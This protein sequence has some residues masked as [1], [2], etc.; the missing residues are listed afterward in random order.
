MKSLSDDFMN[1]FLQPIVAAIVVIFAVGM[2]SVAEAGDR[3]DYDHDALSLG[4]ESA[5]NLFGGI[6]GGG[7]FQSAGNGGFT[8][9]NVSLF[10][11]K[12]GRWIGAFA[13]GQYDFPARSFMAL[14]GAE[15]GY[16]IVGID[17][18]LATRFDEGGPSF[19][20]QGSALLTVGV[21]SLF[22]RYIYWPESEEQVFQV[23][24]TL[25][26]PLIAPWGYDPF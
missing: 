24:L 2:G 4:Y 23:G 20:P 17:A 18:G 3:E 5:W 25:K 6:S 19:G 12:H 21:I 9:A 15:I 11:L 14:G 22:G 7:S 16:K 13:S 1:R 10:R 26:V 8:G